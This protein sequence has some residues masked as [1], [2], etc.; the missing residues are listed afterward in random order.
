[1][2]IRI[3]D[4]PPIRHKLSTFKRHENAILDPVVLAI[5]VFSRRGLL[6]ETLSRILL[7]AQAHANRQKVIRTPADAHKPV[8][9]HLTRSASYNNPNLKAASTAN[10]RHAINA[11]G[12]RGGLSYKLGSHAA[13]RG[14]AQDANELEAGQFKAGTS[15][16]IS[17]ALGHSKRTSTKGLTDKYADGHIE[18]LGRA[19]EASGPN[20]PI[21]TPFTNAVFMSDADPQPAATDQQPLTTATTHKSDMCSL[22][23]LDDTDGHEEVDL[24]DSLAEADGATQLLDEIISG[25]N[26]NDISLRSCG[27]LDS[28]MYA[29]EGHDSL[30]DNSI[31]STC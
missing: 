1:M 31:M 9:L 7:K 22:L 8:L 3:R 18:N 23:D 16:Q 24:N 10:I 2:R 4:S 30:F 14:V 20:R 6:H 29:D 19:R 12:A 28:L 17:A 26:V 11:I 21:V 13:R 27:T 15:L 25:V 5:A